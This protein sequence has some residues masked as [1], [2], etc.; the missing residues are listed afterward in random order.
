MYLFYNDIYFCRMFI[1]VMS[2][3]KKHLMSTLKVTLNE[4]LDL[5]CTLKSHQNRFHI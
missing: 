5:K 1:C 4:K 2:S 3:Q